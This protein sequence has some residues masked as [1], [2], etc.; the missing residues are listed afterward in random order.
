MNF[1]E[2]SGADRSRH[3]TGREPHTT[4]PSQ[5][6]QNST[7]TPTSLIDTLLHL[8]RFEASLYSSKILSS[9]QNYAP[10]LTMVST[11]P[12]A[13]GLTSHAYWQHGEE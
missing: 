4:H 11:Q 12:N 8:E 5:Q 13:T 1:V 7:S 9:I 3:P 2:V 10:A 6:L